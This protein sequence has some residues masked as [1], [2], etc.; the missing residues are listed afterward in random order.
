MDA[1]VSNSLR[2]TFLVH[3]IL[4]VI[5]GAA[6]FL[7]PGRT[8]IFLGAQEQVQIRTSEG[9]VT[10]PGTTFVDP[11]TSRIL[12]AAYLAMGFSS[13][14]GWRASRREQ[15]NVLVQMELIFSILAVV[16]V[17][18]VEYLSPPGILIPKVVWA[19]AAILAAFA[20]AWGLAL[21][22]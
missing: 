17:L 6:L 3:M 10:V 15:V 7:I 20:V 18:A 12:G 13:F 11:I 2:I 19:I 21:R 8:S 14:V 1:P 4:A 16:A 22:R 9:T 5:F